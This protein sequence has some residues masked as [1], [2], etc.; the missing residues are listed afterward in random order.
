V[1]AV[2]GGRGAAGKSVVAANLA[3]SLA[4]A[5][6]TVAVVDLDPEAPSQHVLLGA[7]GGRPGLTALLDDREPPEAALSETRHPN[8]RLVIGATGGVPLSATSRLQT[9][10]R[11]LAVDVVVLDVGVAGDWAASA[12]FELGDQR[13][14]VA[15]PQGSSIHD[16]YGLFK[17]AVV[18]DV[19]ARL[20]RASQLGRYEAEHGFNDGDKIGELLE[21]VRGRDPALAEEIEDALHEFGGYVVGTEVQDATQL[22]VFQTLAKMAQ[23]YLGIAL[24]LLSWLRVN[25]RLPELGA[26]RGGL[27]SS[28]DEARAFRTMAD[29]IVESLPALP[30]E[31]VPIEV[32]MGDESEVPV[33]RPHATP[34]PIPLPLPRPAPRATPEPKPAPAPIKPRVHVPQ[35]RTRTPEPKSPSEGGGSR[36]KKTL[37]GMPPVRVIK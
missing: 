14:A 26:V 3:W 27:A 9:R 21:R 25:A 29:A 22:G 18:R 30:S 32:D 6:R 24:P 19:R 36:R 4:Q 10:L 8:L 5:G 12:S 17:A 11:E 34:P 31:D 7:T 23:D 13:I 33:R 2:S 16:A 35:R 20:E 28:S 1:V 15:T 37:P